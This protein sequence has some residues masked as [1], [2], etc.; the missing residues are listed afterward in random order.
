[1]ENNASPRQKLLTSIQHVMGEL[2]GF[3]DQDF[4]NFADLAEKEKIAIDLRTGEDHFTF[5]HAANQDMSK[6]VLI[7][8]R[9]GE[10]PEDRATESLARLMD[11]NYLASPCNLSAFAIDERT[12]HA[13]YT[14][15]CAISEMTETTL[16]QLLVGIAA[17]A[18]EW[19]QGFFLEEPQTALFQ[20]YTTQFAALA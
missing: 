3:W 6:R 7:E 15:S 11:L 2:G 16:S 5:V 4:E 17:L 1:M 14:Y 10:I 12:G 20:N 18:H 8:C 9:L 19:R 13:I